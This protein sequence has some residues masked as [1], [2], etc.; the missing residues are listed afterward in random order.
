M[1]QHAQEDIALT[2]RQQRERD[3]YERFSAYKPVGAV[4]LAAFQ[5]TE[6]RP[7]NSY[8]FAKQ[9]VCSLLETCG[10][11]LL[12]FGC[13]QGADAVGYAHVGFNVDAFDIT[14]ANLDNAR[15]LARHYGVADKIRFAIQS[16]EQLDY[17]DGQF[18]VVTGTN[19]LHHCEVQSA[20]D[21]CHR[22]LRRGGVAVFREHVEIPLLEFVRMSPPVR[23]LWPRTPSLEHHITEDETNLSNKDIQYMRG[24]FS[25]VDLARFGFFSRLRRIIPTWNRKLAKI[26]YALF[27][28]CPWCQSLGMDVV[29]ELHKS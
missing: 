17:D 16:A 19:I 13:G 18:D 21:E 4:T 14:P 22:V 20:V 5:G 28:A 27:R 26:D 10:Q 2:G 29:I 8:W 24:L 7:W 6:T 15:N 11:R 1:T 25:Q 9:R 23:W 3:Y 12:E